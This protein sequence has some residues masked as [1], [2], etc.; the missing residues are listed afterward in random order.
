MFV[1]LLSKFIKAYVNQFYLFIEK[2]KKNEF[3]KEG[4]Y[5][6]GEKETL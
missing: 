2:R 5:Q 3:A 1:F 4:Q 6:E